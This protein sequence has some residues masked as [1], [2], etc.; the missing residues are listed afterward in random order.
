MNFIKDNH[1]SLTLM[2]VS[3]WKKMT[4]KSQLLVTTTVLESEMVQQSKLKL[5][6]HLKEYIVQDFRKNT[7][8][9]LL[10]LCLSWSTSFSPQ[11]VS[12]SLMNY[13]TS[14]FLHFLILPSIIFHIGDGHLMFL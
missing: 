2:K 10:Q 4:M 7:G 6:C 3:S 12:P 9:R 14:P 13:A 8:K 5:E 11:S 1:Y